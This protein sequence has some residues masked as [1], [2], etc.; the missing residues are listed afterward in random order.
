MSSLTA[1]PPHI[2]ADQL[3][4]LVGSRLCHDLVSPL[5]AIGNGIELLQMSGEFPRLDESPE[6]Q[7]MAEA[8]QSAQARIQAF[9]MAFGHAPRD[10]RIGLPDLTRLAAASVA[11]DRCHVRIEAAGDF[12]RPEARLILLALMC[13]D[14]AM[15]RGGQILAVHIAPGWR[16]VAESGWMKPDPALW[17]WLDGDAAPGLTPPPA[18]HVQFALLA[19]AARSAGRRLQWELD[20]TGAEIRL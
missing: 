17:S 10:Q 20:Q 5:G 1:P 8:V 12:A 16:L 11:Q 7:M 3:A 2:A 14:A 9:R 6:M 13:L 4:A 19:E 15:P 18:S